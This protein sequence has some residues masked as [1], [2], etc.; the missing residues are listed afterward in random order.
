MSW[1][2]SV[3][4]LRVRDRLAEIYT[5]KMIATSL[6]STRTCEAGKM[7]ESVVELAAKNFTR[8]F[9]GKKVVVS[10]G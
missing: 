1:L 7:L 8:H 5:V 10:A 9:F 2:G 6:Y 3:R 4:S